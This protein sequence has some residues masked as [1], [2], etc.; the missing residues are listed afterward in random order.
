MA[1]RA[2]ALRAMETDVRREVQKCGLKGELS[3]DPVPSWVRETA[4]AYSAT[5]PV[6]SKRVK[7]VRTDLILLTVAASGANL[8]PDETFLRGLLTL[9]AFSL[10]GRA[11]Y[12]AANPFA[13]YEHSIECARTQE[14]EFFRS[15]A[16]EFYLGEGAELTGRWGRDWVNRRDLQEAL[17]SNGFLTPSGHLSEEGGRF[18]F[19]GSSDVTAELL[20]R[21]ASGAGIVRKSMRLKH[22]TRALAESLLE[23]MENRTIIALLPSAPLGP[24]NRVDPTDPRVVQNVQGKLLGTERYVA[25]PA[26]LEQD[27]GLTDEDCSRLHATFIE[28]AATKKKE[29]EAAEERLMLARKSL[30]SGKSYTPRLHR[31]G[32]FPPTRPSNGCGTGWSTSAPRG[33]RRSQQVEEVKS[34]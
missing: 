1:S 3:T 11:L 18:V 30:S 31:C 15:A 24:Y 14:K 5:V 13:P 28:R 23:I 19:A 20:S 26:I 12:V 9:V 17:Q 4:D 7:I 29:A 6:F 25:S 16:E 32:A 21:N 27:L 34:M 8:A 22:L 33:Q 10:L 2:S